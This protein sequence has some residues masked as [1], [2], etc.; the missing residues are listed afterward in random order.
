MLCYD[1]DDVIQV[2]VFMNTH[3]MLAR[4]SKAKPS[5][6]KN[7]SQFEEPLRSL[8]ELQLKPGPNMADALFDCLAQKDL[9]FKP[10]V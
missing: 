3:E 1:L 5:D 7:S 8:D 2:G 10:P 6:D 9:Q 4:M